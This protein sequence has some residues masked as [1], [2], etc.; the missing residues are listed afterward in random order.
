MTAHST[1]EQQARY[2]VRRDLRTVRKLLRR[3][4]HAARTEGVELFGR[5]IPQSK[6][7]AGERRSHERTSLEWPI[8]IQP[9]A[10]D[11]KNAVG[12]AG[13]GG[14][15]LGT[16]RDVSLRGVG[17]THDEPLV[18]DYAVVFFHG[19]RG[20]EVSLLLEIRWSNNENGGLYLSGG[21]FEGMV[22]TSPIA[23][24]R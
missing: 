12:L 14:I 7:W 19:R 21:R 11:G 8:R 10:Y 3:L 2:L 20:D 22:E 13:A 17:F 15:L 18:G 5:R 23:S 4:R 6:R 1:A 24:G 16:T 9:V